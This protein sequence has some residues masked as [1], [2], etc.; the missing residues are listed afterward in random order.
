MQSRKCKYLVWA[1]Q[2]QK[3]KKTSCIYSTSAAPTFPAEETNGHIFLIPLQHA[4][5]FT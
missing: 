5:E 1:K 3:K 4:E 2:Q